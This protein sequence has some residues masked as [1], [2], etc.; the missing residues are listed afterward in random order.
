MLV[1]YIE[2][3]RCHQ[4]AARGDLRRAV[5]DE[6]SAVYHRRNRSHRHD[7]SHGQ[8]LHR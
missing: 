3:H 8:L 1:I 2:S 5:G 6:Y 7:A 4:Q